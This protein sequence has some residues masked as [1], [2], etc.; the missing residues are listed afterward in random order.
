M[1][2]SSYRSHELAFS[3]SLLERG[4]WLYIWEISHPDWSDPEHYVGRTGDSSS[5]NAASPFNRMGQHLNLRPEARAAML[6]QRLRNTFPLINCSGFFYRLV[7]VGPIFPEVGVADRQ[8]PSQEERAKHHEGR[9]VVSGLESMLEKKM[10][11]A[12]YK[13]LNIVHSKKE[14]SALNLWPDVLLAFVSH[15]PKLANS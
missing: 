4:F 6:A 3:G 2:E 15:F 14:E 5:V 10:R 7:S 13:V 1:K 9:D 12:G 11:S 8:T